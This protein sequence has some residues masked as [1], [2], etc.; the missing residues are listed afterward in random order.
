[1][2]PLKRKA[3][4]EEQGVPCKKRQR[5]LAAKGNYTRVP[6]STRGVLPI[7]QLEW[8]E[9]A[10]PDRL[11]DAEGFFGLEEVENVA[12]VRDAKSGN[13]FYK[14]G[15][16][17]SDANCISLTIIASCKVIGCKVLQ[18]KTSASLSGRWWSSRLWRG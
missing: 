10:L 9:V 2:A 14:V 12:V 18:Q 1:M 4:H 16:I 11:E 17:R 15:R 13:V 3:A 8:R 5:T 7:D 6:F